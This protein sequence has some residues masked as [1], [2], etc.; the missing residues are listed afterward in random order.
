MCITDQVGLI[1]RDHMKFV[2]YMVL[3]YHIFCK[4]PTFHVPIF[5][6]L[7]HVHVSSSVSFVQGSFEKFLTMDS[8]TYLVLNLR[9]PLLCYYT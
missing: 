6:F 5:M 7:F 3:V 9:G 2:I 4:L 1:T 8:F